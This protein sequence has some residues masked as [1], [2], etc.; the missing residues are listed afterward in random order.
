MEETVAIIFVGGLVLLF[1]ASLVWVYRDAEARGKSGPLMAVLAWFTW[2]W[3]LLIWLVARP[4]VRGNG[5]YFR[6]SSSRR[7]GGRRSEATRGP[8]GASRPLGRGRA[9][10]RR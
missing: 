8:A 7:S 4:P 1:F 6:M 2:P 9:R 10:S 5:H 3:G